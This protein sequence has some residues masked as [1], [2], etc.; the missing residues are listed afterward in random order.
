MLHTETFLCI[1]AFLKLNTISDINNITYPIQKEIKVFEKKFKS[2]LSSD[3]SMLDR[4]MHF[5]IKRKGKKIRPILVLLS[6]QAFGK[7]K[8]ET[9]LASTMIELLHTATLIHDDVIDEANYRRGFFSVNSLWK[10]K[11]SVLVGDFLLSKGLL[12]AV[13]NSEFSLL[14]IV[15]DA[16]KEMSEGELL[17][18]EKARRLDITE[19]MYFKIIRKKTASLIA[20][21]CASGVNSVS[22]D[23]SL[24]KKMREF[25]ENAG[26]A[27]QIK[28]DLLD[29]SNFSITGK[30]RG[31]DIKSKKITLPLIYTLNKVNRSTKRIILNTVKMNDKSNE[32]VEKVIKIIRDEGGVDYAKKKMI[33]YQESALSILNSLP[34]NKAVE[35][36]KLLTNYIVERKK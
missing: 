33:L 31:T 35:S 29:Y 9:Y 4:V 11:V 34:N 2:Y 26:I 17:Q 21:C 7:I 8:E 12:L 28:D 36:L 14:R 24:I 23:E 1:F 22:K 15:S 3:I 13:N 19:D 18:I 5:I 20:A 25:G 10:N 27:F 16:V 32:K 6:A 30:I